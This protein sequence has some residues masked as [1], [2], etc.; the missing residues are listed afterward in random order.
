L[1]PC[2]KWP[3]IILRNRVRS[4]PLLTSPLSLMHISRCTQFPQ[5]T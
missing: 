5:S 4:S 3:V 2:R 1:P